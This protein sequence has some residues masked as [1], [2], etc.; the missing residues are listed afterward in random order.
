MYIVH[1][2]IKVKPEKVTDF[3]AVTLD[4][5]SNSLKEPGVVRFDCIQEIEDQ[6]HFVLVEVYRT[7][8]DAALHKE[9]SHYNRW[10]EM[11]EPMMAEPR[12]RIIYQNVYPAD[13]DWQ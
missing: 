2:F 3:K 7:K 6:T 12:S 8:N 9:T 11:A 5:A 4:N 13:A 10:R 1:V